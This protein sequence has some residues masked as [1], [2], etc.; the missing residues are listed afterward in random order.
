MIKKFYSLLFLL[1]FCSLSYAQNGDLNDKIK[2]NT[3]ALEISADELLEIVNMRRNQSD[4]TKDV[5]VTIKVVNTNSKTEPESADYDESDDSTATEY[6][7][8]LLFKQR[9]G[10]GYGKQ[11][12]EDKEKYALLEKGVSFV[13]FNLGFMGTDISDYLLEPVAEVETLYNRNFSAKISAGHFVSNNTAIGVKFSY[14]FTDLRLKVTADILDLLIGAQ[15][16]ETNNVKSMY[17]GGVYVRN[18]I[19]LDNAHRFFIISETGLN[20][21]YTDGLSKNI[22]DEGVNIT[23]V[24]TDKDAVSLGISPGFMYFMSRG[25]AFE[26]SMSPVVAYWEKSRTVNNEVDYG[27]ADNYGLTFKF[28]PFNISFGFSYY[29]GLDYNK[30]RKYLKKLNQY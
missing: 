9:K 1:T 4:T 20:Y 16:Y 8:L 26:F 23:K 14:N 21:T 10:K 11:P 17:S 30:N 22:Y 3:T 5:D 12:F 7:N 25:F 6:H 28:M 19:P 29:F 13:N 18:F 2:S 24:K 15:T 27:S